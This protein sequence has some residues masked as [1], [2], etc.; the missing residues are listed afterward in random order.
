VK[1]EGGRTA[2]EAA[3]DA[4]AADGG[5]HDGDNVA[6]L[7]LERGVEVRAALHRRE[8]VRVRELGEHADVGR[9]LELEACAM[10]SA[11]LLF[12]SSDAEI[13]GCARVA[14]MDEVGGRVART[15]GVY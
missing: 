13:G 15:T 9:V 1:R 3:D 12:F 4:G 11:G 10:M 7:G 2:R 6:E 8:A 14:M 5:V